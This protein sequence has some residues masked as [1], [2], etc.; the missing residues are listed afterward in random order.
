MALWLAVALSTAHAL[1]L[2]TAHALVLQPSHATLPALTAPRSAGLCMLSDLPVPTYAEYRAQ[3]DK[4]SGPSGPAPPPPPPLWPRPE[5]ADWDDMTGPIEVS[6]L[7]YALCPSATAAGTTAGTFAGAAAAMVS[8]AVSRATNAGT[9]TYVAVATNAVA[10][11][12]ITK[13]YYYILGIYP[14][15]ARV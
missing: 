4:S 14:K 7:G 11:A 13:H 2:S 1:M 6:E 15:E 8:N 5:A 12:A 10:A 3:L 9:A